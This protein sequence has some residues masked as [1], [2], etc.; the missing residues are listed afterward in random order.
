MGSL[1]WEGEVPHA[2][3]QM[4]CQH[5][6]WRQNPVR[7]YI[8][9]LFIF[10]YGELKKF[11]TDCWPKSKWILLHLL[12]SEGERMNAVMT[13]HLHQWWSLLMALVLLPLL[14]GWSSQT[15]ALS[16]S[17]SFLLGPFFLFYFHW[18][19]FL[20]FIFIFFSIELSLNFVWTLKEYGVCYSLRPLSY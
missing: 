5:L 9:E 2:H 10:H 8:E 12:R 16:L 18:L 13:R 20:M 19:L 1:V 4:F 14:I 15:L 6:V 3:G 11:V 17:F 7:V